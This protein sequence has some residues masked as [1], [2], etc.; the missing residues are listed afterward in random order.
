MSKSFAS[1]KSTSA[2]ISWT[3]GGSI[4]VGSIVAAGVLAAVV[5]TAGSAKL[6]QHRANAP[7]QQLAAA[8]V[9]APALNA[10][11]QGR[12]RASLDSLPL[13]FEAN[14]GQTDP[15][16]KYTAR[17]NGYTV[18]LTA[19]DTV[20]AMTSQ[21]SPSRVAGRHGLSAAARGTA[22]GAK[23]APA[24]I[25]MRPVG[26]NS[27]PE[28]AAG[29][30]LP[31]Q[32]NYFNGSDPS[33]WK[34]GVKQYA[35]V[36]YR[37]VYPGVDMAFHGQQRQ[38]EFDFIVAPG[39]DAARIAMGFTGAKKLSLDA[40]G[41]LS[42][43]TGA[44]D[45]VLHKPVAYQER[46]G[47]RELVEVAFDVKGKQEAAFRLG[48]YD[49][50]RELVIDPS[51]SYATYLGGAGEDEVFAIALDGSGNA[52]L[53]GQTNSLSFDG[54]PAGP[55]FNVFVTKL[56]PN[57][58]GFVYTDI[59]AATGG[60]LAC[61]PSGTGSCSGN[62]IAVDSTGNAYVA[63]AATAGFPTHAG[64]QTTF[65]GGGSDAFA[66]KLNSTGTLVYSTFLGG[67]G[68]DNANAIA[69][70]GAG[71]A[72]VA[73]E[74]QSPNF[75]TK[76]P[77]QSPSASS[78][79]AFITAVSSAGTSLVYSTVLGGSNTNLATG[80][81]LDGSN[82][83]YV[84]GI[85]DSSDFPTTA[86]VV[87]AQYGGSEDGFVTEV[88][89][90]GSAWVYS[91]YLGGSGTDDALGIAVDAAGEAYVTGNTGSTNF[92]TANPAQNALGG[93]S[94]TNVFVT[95]LNAGAT[96]L[97]FSTYYGGNLDDAGAGIALD[98]FGDAYVTGATTSANYP[99]TGGG[100]TLSGTSDAFVTEFSN[101]GF[102]VY[103]SF[104]GG[105]GTE[106]QEVVA[107]NITGPFGAIA[108]DSSSN[109]YLAGI[110][111]STT[112]FPI[113]SSGVAQPNY[114]GG[115]ADG[116]V[117]KVGAAP[118]DFS[119]A[120]APTATS[121][122]SGQ[123]TSAITVTVSSVNASYGQAV[124]LSCGSLP[125][126]SACHFTPA[127]V[128]PGSSAVTSSLTIST[129]GTSS[130]SLLTPGTNRGLP[131]FYAMFL[132]IG[133]IALL[134]MGKNSR[135]KRLFGFLLL[136]I[137]LMGLVMLPACGG[138]NGGGGGGNN[139]TPGT[140]NITVSGQAGGATHSAPLTF[141]VN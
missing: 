60:G 109:A 75:P 19:K 85:T 113:T 65:G 66:L 76:N 17:G 138:S 58:T 134:G 31:G 131:V 127:S 64:F 29:R 41:N 45:V 42:L 23:P 137:I 77:I 48:A 95:K 36:S 79:D 107:S 71:N 6:S 82:N 102:V 89:A 121:T 46:D 140:Y 52:Y 96:A 129:N 34:L 88:K 135:R 18:F 117:A 114:G 141:T 25:Y 8:A 81:A 94:A 67:S 13:A 30:E 24:A 118:A 22:R 111:S 61:S 51:L 90:D 87:Q 116:F 47:N 100:G 120:V 68:R 126:K 12:V 105:S 139:T 123:S 44:G 104:L 91:T 40:A 59:F 32:T 27:R 14:Q 56:N 11:Q 49:H 78:N 53:T 54:K 119:V 133:G 70:D 108:V 72:Y 101:T 99:V 10:Q 110:T 128:T 84:V 122:A 63:G 125:S 73:G 1:K 28:I 130:S 132:P 112:G 97:L 80:I 93:A 4:A 74:T 39:A 20:F 92:P 7:A 2:G 86:G 115:A 35:T 62:A 3:G 136:G 15:Q 55:T 83:A 43:A 21:T 33:N 9:Y 26:G 124:A 50:Q 106:N 38:L 103:S 57:G 37:N 16:V 69:I 98:S 5:V